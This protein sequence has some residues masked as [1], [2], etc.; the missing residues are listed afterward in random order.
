MRQVSRETSCPRLF[1]AMSDAVLL[2]YHG[3][4]ERLEDVAAFV[5]R[6]RHGRPAPADVV[7]EVQRR[8]RVIGGSPLRAISEAQ[9]AALESKLGLPCRAAARLWEPS[10]GDVIDDLK[11]VG[12]TRVVSLPLAPLSLSVYHRALRSEAPGL[13]V[14]EIAPWV[15]EPAWA[16]LCAAPIIEALRRAGADGTTVILSAHSLPEK[17]IAA[18]DRYAADFERMCA[19]IAARLNGATVKV[20]YQSQGMTGDAWLGPSLKDMLEQSKREGKLGAIV[21]PVGFVADH[22]ETLYD[23]DVEAKAW[24]AELGLSWQRLPALGVEPAFI[25]FL[26][27]KVRQVL[28]CA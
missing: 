7:E 16:S 23:L 8:L 27:S 28:A 13:D 10:I 4:V 15:D 19:G 5:Q 20:C 6:I 12:V 25:E 21:A 17:I 2:S 24:A 11:S 26:A 1:V 22:V 18:G 14:V 9:A 3:A